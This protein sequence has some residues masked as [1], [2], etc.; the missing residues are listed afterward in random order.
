MITLLAWSLPT[1]HPSMSAL[2]LEA[3]KML[4]QFGY[5]ATMCS[6]GTPR[7]LTAAETAEMM[8]RMNQEYLNNMLQAHINRLRT[9]GALAAPPH[10]FPLVGG[11][12]SGEPGGVEVNM[13]D[14]NGGVH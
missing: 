7:L 3:P 4:A 11:A 2:I 14:A 6:P 10:H 8:P 1:M 13:A 9:E 5:F 12:I